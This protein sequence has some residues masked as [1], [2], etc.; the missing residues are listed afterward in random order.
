MAVAIT[1]NHLRK[2]FILRHNRALGIK[3]RFLGLVYKDKREHREHFVALDDVSFEV[4]QGEALGL[5]GHNGSGKSTLLQIIAGILEP[6]MGSVTTKGRVAPL[7]QLGVG[8]TP[9]LTGYDNIFLNASLYGFQ[10]RDVKK[11]LKDIIE[12]SELEHFID[13]PLKNYSSGMQMRLGFSVAVHLDPD[14]L[15]ADE[16]LAVGDQQFQEKCL[17]KILEM[18]NAGMTLILVSHSP[19]QVRSF[20]DQCI[21][22]DHGQVVECSLKENV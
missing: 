18:R 3:S 11:R 13:T 9:E 4:E 2:E 8:F 21:R 12:F 22:L 15:L 1:V 6:T 16:I 5:I 7:I 20:C 17:I 14:I 10:N 19:E